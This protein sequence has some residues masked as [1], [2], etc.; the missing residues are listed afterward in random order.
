MRLSRESR[1][2]IEALLTLADDGPGRYVGTRR[3]A[4]QAGLPMAYLQKILRQ[5]AR[6]GVLEAARGRGFAL[7]RPSTEISLREVLVAI[8]G[9]DLFGG[10]CIFWREECSESDPCELHFRWKELKPAVED[11]IARTTLDEVRRRGVPAH[12]GAAG[13]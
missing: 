2:A 11:A 9:A 7:S 6:A 12:L 8:E 1:Y 4:A 5:L 10:R 13:A 3:I